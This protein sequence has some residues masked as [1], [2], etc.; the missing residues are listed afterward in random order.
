MHQD[1]VSLDWSLINSCIFPV[2]KNIL[3]FLVIL[4]Q[5][6]PQDRDP[7]AIYANNE[8]D[9]QEIEVYGFD[10]DYT[11]ASYTPALHYLIYNLGREVLVTDHKV[12][13]LHDQLLLM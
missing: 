11:L 1:L 13:F 3:N 2:T 9:L 7:T 6:L 8:L 4:A 10:Y 5:P 12:I